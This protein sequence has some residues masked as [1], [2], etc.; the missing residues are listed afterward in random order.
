MPGTVLGARHT[1]NEIDRR[2]SYSRTYL[3]LTSKETKLAQRGGPP[4]VSAEARGW[5]FKP[6][7]V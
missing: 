1:V 2:A 3:Q 7:F 4:F 5:D 6:R